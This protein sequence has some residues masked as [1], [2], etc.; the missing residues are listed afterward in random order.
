MNHRSTSRGIT[1]EAFS[2]NFQWCRESGDVF[3]GLHLQFFVVF[4]HLGGFFFGVFIQLVQQR[5]R[6]PYMVVINNIIN[7]FRFHVS[8]Q[9]VYPVKL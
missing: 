3:Q 6:V 8:V 5:V 2:L 9:T 4:I 7:L 1:A